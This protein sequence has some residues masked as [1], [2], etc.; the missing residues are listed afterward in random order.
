[1][2]FRRVET[3]PDYNLAHLISTEGQWEIGL[4]STLFGAR[5]RMG[6]VG[7][8]GCELDYCAGDDY[9]FQQE[10]LRTVILALLPV[11]ETISFRELHAIF[12]HCRV[13]PVCL[14]PCWDVLR[15]LAADALSNAVL[16]ADEPTRAASESPG[17]PAE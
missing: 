17:H 3:V 12:P 6:R 4:W 7:N 2:I 9:D 8:Q 16:P 15:R 13:K 14:D 11:P 10:L 5:V 1:M